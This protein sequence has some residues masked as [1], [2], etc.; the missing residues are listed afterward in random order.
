MK[1]NLDKKHMDIGTPE[2]LWM[3]ATMS[4]STGGADLAEC[5]KIMESVN[6]SDDSWVNAWS[7]K[8]EELSEA[9]K[10]HLN[11]Q[12]NITARN[13]LLR[14]STY[15]RTAMMRCHAASKRADDLLT[16]SRECYIHALSYINTSVQ[17][18]KIPFGE[19]LLPA[20]YYNSGK[21][22]APTLIGI[23]GGDSTNEEMFNLLG[24]AAIERGWNCLVY[25][26]PGQYTA[27]QLNPDLHLMANWE[28]PNGAV[29]DWLIER[30]EVAKDKI[31]LF[32]WS[33][34]SNLAIRAAAIDKRISAVISNGLIVDVYEAFYGVWPGWLQRAKPEYFD[35]LFHLLEKINAQVRSITG[36]F[37]QMHG[38]HS[39]TEMIR[40]WKPFNV[41]AFADKLTCPVLF[42]TGE[43]EYA[44]QSAGPL[45]LS[46]GKFL[47][48]IQTPAWFYEFNYEDG[49]AASHC[50]IGAQQDLQELVYNWLEK[51]LI[52][53]ETH[54]NQEVKLHDFS[55]V[56]S[57]FGK[58]PEVKKIL[59]EIRIQSFE[60]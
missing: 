24:F 57:Y 35:F 7:K 32:G 26:G 36:V 6:S 45:I 41:A 29:V 39:P 56:I 14:A 43:A 23:N 27:R 37:Y 55:R 22:D 28:A 17:F 15:F 33:L 5:L 11:E 25:E 48:N 31:A 10:R 2:Y 18:V 46:I 9:S 60:I 3:R 44:E 53:P 1:L 58:M 52:H 49:W 59:S 40:A 19:N 20:Y 34:S 21:P 12:R 4:I 38:V 42:I 51:V 13:K 50:Q 30:P 16:K 54:K 47:N 8:G